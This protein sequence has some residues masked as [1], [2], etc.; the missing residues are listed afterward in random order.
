MCVAVEYVIAMHV[1]VRRLLGVEHQLEA[2]RA[3]IEQERKLYRRQV[4]VARREAAIN[5]VWVEVW[6][7]AFQE[8]VGGQPPL[9]LDAVLARADVMLKAKNLDKPLPEFDP[10]G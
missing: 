9:P 10:G 5:A 3:Q 4:A 2:E 8:V 7:G 1:E 6:G